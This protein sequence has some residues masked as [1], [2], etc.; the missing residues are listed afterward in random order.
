[1]TSPPT[2]PPLNITSDDTNRPVIWLGDT[3]ITRW[4]ATVTI[5]Q[6][7]TDTQVVANLTATTATTPPPPMAVLPHHATP[8]PSVG[9][10]G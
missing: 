3:D 7:G 4:C 5:T 9:P 10:G 6:T 2:T 1:M 8:P